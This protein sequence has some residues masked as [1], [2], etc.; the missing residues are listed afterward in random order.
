MAEAATPRARGW[1]RLALVLV[2]TTVGVGPGRFLFTGSPRDAYVRW[3]DRNGLAG[4][5]ESSTRWR[6]TAST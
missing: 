4:A 1:L 3:L 2:A 5:S 6:P